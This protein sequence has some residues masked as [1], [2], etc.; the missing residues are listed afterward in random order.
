[1]DANA[2]SHGPAQIIF[3]E[4]SSSLTAGKNNQQQRNGNGR[5]NAF[6]HQPE[7][8]H[9]HPEMEH[10]PLT[11]AMKKPMPK[12]DGQQQMAGDARMVQVD[13]RGLEHFVPGEPT[14]FVVDT[15]K[16]GRTFQMQIPIG[17]QLPISS[18]VFVPFWKT[19]LFPLFIHFIKKTV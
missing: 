3:E 7:P 13:G 5:L 8:L 14:E 12:Y 2:N 11:T 6:F 18:L 9:R 10:Q 16:T 17:Q 4:S 15:S 1:V 19:I